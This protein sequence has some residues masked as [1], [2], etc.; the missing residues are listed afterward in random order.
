MVN[1]QESPKP[2]SLPF[3]VS[4]SIREE[5]DDNI[6]T[7]KT[8]R[9]DDF[10][11]LI[12]PGVFYQYGNDRT[13]F[14]AAY[15]FSVT[16]FSQRAGKSFDFSHDF[17]VG[18]VH[19]FSDRFTLDIRDRLPI[20]QEPSLFDGG[21]Q[22]RR[23]GD[24]INNSFSAQLDAQW[25]PKFGTTTTVSSDLE[26]YS[27]SLVKQTNNRITYGI[28]NDFRF[29]LKPTITL[30]ASGGYTLNDYYDAT[31]AFDKSSTLYT[32]SG[33]V[34]WQALPNLTLSARGGYQTVENTQKIAG[35]PSGTSSPYAKFTINW[36][37]GSKSSFDFDYSHTSDTTDVSTAFTTETDSVVLGGRYLFTPNLSGRL[38]GRYSRNKYNSNNSLAGTS[39]TE[40]IVGSDFTLTY[41]IRS[42]ISLEAGHSFTLVS[43]DNILREYDRNQI[44]FGIRASY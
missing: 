23:Q 34:E 14:S 22:T 8:N 6:N 18:M 37:A 13:N 19:K 40:Q 25:L 4:A 31:P 7:T 39:S 5:Y 35:Q 44:F 30:I 17:S 28:T 12:S 27:D 38:S 15:N 11:T 20:G 43:S 26:D 24:Y 33:G 36:K 42:Y 10:K 2:K 21:T 29:T 16:Y 32:G 1:A 3:T 41:R 9:Q